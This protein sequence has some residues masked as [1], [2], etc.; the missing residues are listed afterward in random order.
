M[1]VRVL[2]E[3]GTICAEVK[4]TICVQLYGTTWLP[5]CMEP[6]AIFQLIRQFQVA[7]VLQCLFNEAYG[8]WL[9]LSR[10]GMGL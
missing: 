9:L 10:T 4:G 3:F 5:R 2:K 8:E 1:G 7:I 6:C